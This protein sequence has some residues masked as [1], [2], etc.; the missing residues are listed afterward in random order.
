MGTSLIRAC[1]ETLS[2]AAFDDF[3]MIFIDFSMIFDEFQ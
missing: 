3:S 1:C 2:Q